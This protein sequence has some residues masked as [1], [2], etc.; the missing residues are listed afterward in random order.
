MNRT[1]NTVRK[2]RKNNQRGGFFGIFKKIKSFYKGN[3][4]N[5]PNHKTINRMKSL[6]AMTINSE[7]SKI[8]QI[9]LERDLY[10]RVLNRS[11]KIKKN[12]KKENNNYFDKKYA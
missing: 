11:K 8:R 6:H 12:I 5:K 10:R 1:R 2:K 9:K 7:L 3:K 4:G